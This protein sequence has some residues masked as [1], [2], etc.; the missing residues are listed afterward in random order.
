MTL[1]ASLRYIGALPEPAM[2]GFTELDA[3]WG[4]RPRPPLELSLRGTNLLHARHTELPTPYGEQIV[5]TIMVEAKL[6]F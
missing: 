6:N 4:W 1:D 3:R 5:R 2:A